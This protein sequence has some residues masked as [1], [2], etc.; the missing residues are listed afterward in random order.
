MTDALKSDTPATDLLRG[1]RLQLQEDAYPKF[2]GPAD[3]LFIT[4]KDGRKIAQILTERILPGGLL[5]PEALEFT[6]AIVLRFNIHDTMMD[7][8]RGHVSATIEAD[9]SDT[10][11]RIE[12]LAEELKTK[13]DAMRIDNEILHREL[14]VAFCHRAIVEDHRDALE[15]ELAECRSLLDRTRPQT[16]TA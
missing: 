2:V 9:P 3:T 7:Q 8:L 15:K 5:R 4:D 10:H 1:Q 13:M 14:A 12:Q 6:Q 11:G 16:V